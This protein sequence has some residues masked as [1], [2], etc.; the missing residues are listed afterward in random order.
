MSKY[1]PLQRFLESQRS[2]EFPMSF[3]EVEAVLGFRLPPSAREHRPWWANGGHA[4]A[5]AWTEAGWETARVD[6]ASERLVFVRSGS[7]SATPSVAI[8]R[9]PAA[10][11]LGSRVSV[12]IEALPPLAA[13]L[14]GDY[15]R[16]LDGDIAKAIARA[17]VEA[18]L[19]RRARH[20]DRIMAQA[21]VTPLDSVDLIREDRD[22]R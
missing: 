22:A 21:S 19:A 3:R 5:R 12:D 14:V 11:G 4:Q 2:G 20:I 8:D 17:L 13:K 7:P 18:A 15:A 10:P 9:A 1:E 16:E 6:L